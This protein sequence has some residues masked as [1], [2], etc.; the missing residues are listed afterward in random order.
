MNPLWNRFTSTARVVLLILVLDM[1]LGLMVPQNTTAFAQQEVSATESGDP[2]PEPTTGLTEQP[3]L[4]ITLQPT[5]VTTAEPTDE[6]TAEP[7]TQPTDELIEEATAQPEA[8]ATQVAEETPTIQPTDGEKNLQTVTGELASI[9][10]GQAALPGAYPWQ[11]ALVKTGK[12]LY[13]GYF[14]G[15]ALVSPRHVLTA[16]SCLDGIKS[17]SE[18]EV[19][20]GVHNLKRPYDGYQMRK[21]NMFYIHPEWDE[22][23]RQYD[24]AVIRLAKPFVL[25]R[26]GPAAVDAIPLASAANSDF[27]GAKGWATGWGM[28]NA[29]PLNKPKLLQEIG[30]DIL[31][32]AECEVAERWGDQFKGGML[33][34]AA[35]EGVV[36]GI[37]VR[38][39]GG[40]LAVKDGG[41]WLLAGVASWG[42]ESYGMGEKP[43]VFTRVSQYAEWVNNRMNYV[44]AELP[45]LLEPAENDMLNGY[46]IPFRWSEA[47]GE[48]Y[49]LEVWTNDN[50]SIK[51][52]KVFNKV[53][54][55]VKV[56]GNGI[57]RAVANKE[58]NKGKYIWR[59]RVQ[60]NNIWGS[61]S[62][63]EKFSVVNPV[64]ELRDPLL[65]VFTDKPTFQWSN[66]L[67]MTRYQVQVYRGKTVVINEI[68][69]TTDGCDQE[70]ICSFITNSEKP[71]I[72]G[73]YKWRV[74]AFN[75]G[76]WN[77]YSA[78]RS[79]IFAPAMARISLSS[80]GVQA[81]D[82]S[83]SPAV[84]ADGRFVAFSSKASNLVAKDTNGYKDVF[85]HDRLTGTT[86]RVSVASDG[87]Q[88]ND[89]SLSPSISA[90]GFLI[91]F[92]SKATNLVAGDTNG[93]E[94]VFVYDR[95]TGITKRVSVSNSDEQGNG[96]SNESV[97]S[98]DGQHV[99]FT[100]LA[101]NLVNA[102]ANEKQ[103]IFK[104][105]LIENS[106]ELI[107]A[108]IAG[109]PGNGLSELSAISEDGRY[110]AFRSL[111]SNLVGDDQN[112]FS[113]VFVRDTVNHTT[114]LVS[115]SSAGEQG[116]QDSKKPTI[117]ADG[118]RVAFIS[119]ATNLVTD[120]HNTTA[121]AFVRDLGSNTT[122]R[123]SVAS[124][125]K[126]S[127]GGPVSQAAISAD[128]R[129]VAFASPQNALVSD[130]TNS[131]EDVFLH[132][133]QNG[134]TISVSL[135]VDG[136]QAND[137]SLHPAISLDGR[138]VIFESQAS[139]LVFNDTNGQTDIFIYHR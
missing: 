42:E 130:D 75:G 37:C 66:I 105:D 30:L 113:D 64:S 115:L 104:R 29:D 133:C 139:N 48:K 5:E 14:C 126:E 61:W 60:K 91:A 82:D 31:S 69:E 93:C 81:N 94:D 90:D 26:T 40:P 120:D 34:A 73:A 84:S 38:D 87:V 33:C 72:Q 8:T 18:F 6:S 24:I 112:I 99:A 116:N 53:Y 3:T 36:G 107:S 41:N 63:G 123:V 58:L 45:V 125:G 122:T 106:T 85:V 49:Q 25:P 108:D 89:D 101:S 131:R 32:D 76:R 57:C 98:A 77:A 71:L 68:V 65:E 43:S 74:C 47:D 44:P 2:P 21:V 23:S 100:S 86:T 103:Q 62:E 51:P 121:D 22:E 127:S 19:V 95:R 136:A 46:R 117:S 135:S 12:G 11:V 92:S 16:A 88:S 7:T 79:F 114:V 124:N 27:A 132:D 20:A 59:M 109:G 1:M 50:D 67:G 129:Y 52:R 137:A 128:G 134:T 15:G 102:A 4:E 119:E 56:C 54:T 9:A 110:V 39:E 118:F 17:A 96:D 111:A 35:E 10:G 83:D 138:H 13:Q 28:M 70:G 55:G 97:I 80:S 78:F